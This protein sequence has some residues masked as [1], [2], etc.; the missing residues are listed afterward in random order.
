MV[1]TLKV[2]EQLRLPDNDQWHLRFHV[3][4][5]SSNRLYIVAQH[6]RKR[7][8]ACSCPGWKRHRTCKH[9]NALRIPSHEQPYEVNIIK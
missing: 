2:D 8:W 1:P 5:E 3:E 9:L 4:S 6:I 7:H